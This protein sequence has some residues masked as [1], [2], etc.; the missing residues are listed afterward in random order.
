M[1]SFVG[2][3]S[4]FGVALGV[5]A[6]IVVLSVMNGFDSEVKK[7]II[8]T[9]SHIIIMKDSGM[10]DPGTEIFSEGELSGLIKS[11]APF[12]TGQAILK[13]KGSVTG[14]LIKGIDPAQE[15]EVTDVIEYIG[16]S[17]E[18]LSGQNVVIG[19]E[20]MKTENLSFGDTIEIMVPYSELNM[21]QVKL[22]VVGSFN[23]G[24]YDYDANI[25]VV[26]L[27]TAQKI[28]RMGKDISGIGLKVND[29]MQVSAIKKHLQ[30]V[31]RYPYIVK[32]WMDLDKNLVS[33]LAL[34]KKM[35]FVI[36]TFIV[37]VACFNIA[38]TLIMMV[39][40]KTK[41]IG[42]MKAI[43][44]SFFGI[45]L[46]FLI[47]GVMIGLF[48]VAIGFSLGILIADRIN[49]IA[50]FLE[51]IT[52]SPVFPSDVYYFTEIPVKI[53]MPDIVSV[54]TV[55]GILAVL[56]GVYPAWKASRQDPVDAIR[57]E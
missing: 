55:A 36:L 40:E 20:L 24:R 23:S 22:K 15:S 37:M 17:S 12:V 47:D 44:A 52:G 3:I 43:G 1:I 46:V 41:D 6:L 30:S 57:Y 21:E 42:I 51:K 48:G 5:A 56:S 27:A 32:T 11:S 26:H 25:A 31:F 14:V 18:G 49:D 7:K 28:F 16:G 45:N 4:V 39:M 35:M 33:A 53:N 10:A 9:Y 19:S 8:G 34:E 29:E 38:G 50:G 13:S 2:V 54:V